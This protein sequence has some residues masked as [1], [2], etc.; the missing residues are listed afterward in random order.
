MSTS[1]GESDLRITTANNAYQFSTV[2]YVKDLLPGDY[3]EVFV[4]SSSNSDVVTF[5]DVHWYTDAH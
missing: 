5:R 1:Y 2:V 4:T 3:L